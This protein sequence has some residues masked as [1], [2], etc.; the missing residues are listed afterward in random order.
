M[1]VGD[2]TIKEQYFKRVETTPYPKDTH[3]KPDEN[4]IAKEEP[5]FKG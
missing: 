4:D 5:E 2:G 1:T 3:T